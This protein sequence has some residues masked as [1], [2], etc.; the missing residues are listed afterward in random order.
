M[1]PAIAVCELVPTQRFN[2]VFGNDNETS[3]SKHELTTDDLAYSCHTTQA[4]KPV[5][6]GRPHDPFRQ[7][8]RVCLRR[9]LDDHG[10]TVHAG[11]LM[12]LTR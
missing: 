11:L 12:A 8:P 10:A 3:I 4:A 7:R 9:R 6:F 2:R 5:N 1:L